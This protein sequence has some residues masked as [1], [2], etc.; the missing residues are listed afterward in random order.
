MLGF[1]IAENWR[2]VPHADNLLIKNCRFYHHASFSP[3]YFLPKCSVLYFPS[4]EIECIFPNS[5]KVLWVHQDA[6]SLKF[7]WL[8]FQSGRNIFL[9]IFA[10]FHIN[11]IRI[12]RSVQTLKFIKKSCYW[13]HSC[14]EFSRFCWQL[15]LNPE[16][17]L[18]S[19]K[20]SQ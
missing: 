2:N 9:S 7:Q 10:T 8:N 6:R 12:H 18:W 3:S 16:T 11:L 4:N 14:R 1:Q 19:L 15:W 13:L 5:K 20:P 17:T